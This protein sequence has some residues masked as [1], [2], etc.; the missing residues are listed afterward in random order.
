MCVNSVHLSYCEVVAY[1]LLGSVSTPPSV[2]NMYTALD[3][4]IEVGE[5]FHR[6]E[7]NLGWN[8]T[9]L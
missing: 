5:L 9:L 8:I 2:L 6:Q 7:I 4:P 1:Y 3:D